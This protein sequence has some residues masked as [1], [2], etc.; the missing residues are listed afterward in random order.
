MNIPTNLSFHAFNRALMNEMFLAEAVQLN[1]LERQE[2]LI[3]PL[4]DKSDSDSSIEN[5]KD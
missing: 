4:F 5:N 2:Q 3:E 1:E